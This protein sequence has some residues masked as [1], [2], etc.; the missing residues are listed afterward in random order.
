MLICTKPKYQNLNSAGFNRRLNIR[1]N[2]L[3][4]MQ[5]VKYLG[6]YV[7]NSLDWK[8]HITTVSSM[9]SKALGFLKHAKKFFRDSSLKALYLII[10]EPYF[11]YC[12]SVWE[13]R[14]TTALLQLQKLQ[15]R[16]ARILTTSAFDTPSSPII[17]NLGYELIFFE[18]K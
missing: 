2:E 16:A 7:D 6:V 13:C 11:R 15:N 12:C 14:G 4:D 1:G 18:S 10:V 3:D 17:K 5:K 9:V 8:E